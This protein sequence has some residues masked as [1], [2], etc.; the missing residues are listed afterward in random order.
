MDSVLY[1]LAKWIRKLINGK[2]K[3][4]KKYLLRAGKN[5]KKIGG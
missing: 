2:W 1:T 5:T 4:I 3:V